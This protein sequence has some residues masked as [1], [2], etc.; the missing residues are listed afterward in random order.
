[1]LVCQCGGT[2]R[3][4]S[5]HFKMV[6]F[7]LRDLIFKKITTH[8]LKRMFSICVPCRVPFK[9]QAFHGRHVAAILCATQATPQV[10]GS[11]WG[12]LEP[13]EGHLP[14]TVGPPVAHAA[15]SRR[16]SPLACRTLLGPIH[17]CHLRQEGLCTQAH[18]SPLTGIL[19]QAR[20]WGSI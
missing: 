15:Q 11:T 3:P 5:V 17:S 20:L 9:T 16:T 18:V 19:R 2:Q 10:L 14:R 8:L 12:H 7:M 4:C 6:N 1:M 13:L